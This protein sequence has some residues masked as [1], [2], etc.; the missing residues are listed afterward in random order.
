MRGKNKKKM[1]AYLLVLSLSLPLG[2]MN[3]GVKR[4]EAA[5]GDWNYEII[6]S[7]TAKITGYTGNETKI[8]IPETITDT[9]DTSYHVTALGDYAFLGQSELEEITI[10]EGVTAIGIYAF[11]G[12][13]S[14]TNISLPD[15]ITDIP[16]FAFRGCMKLTN[17][18]FPAKLKSIGNFAFDSCTSLTGVEL[19]EG[20]TT[21]G[22]NVFYHCTSFRNIKLPSTL[23]SIGKKVF[24]DTS[25]QS[26]TIP[27]NVSSIGDGLFNGLDD[28]GENSYIKINEIVVDEENETY[29]S[30][31]NCNAI[32]ETATDTLLYGSNST[33]KIP[34]GVKII[35]RYAFSGCKDLESIEIPSTV[36][37]VEGHIF[38]K[39]SNLS[40][41]TVSSENRTFDSRGDCNGIIETASNMLVSGC[42]ATKIPADV[43]EIQISAFSGCDGLTE[44]QLPSG[45]QEIKDMTFLGCSGLTSVRIPSG[46]RSIGISAFSRCSSLKSVY[47]PAS[48]EK[49]GEF[50]G[51]SSNGF[52]GCSDLVIY[53]ATGAKAVEFA[54]EYDIPYSFEKMPGEDDTPGFTPPPDTTPPPQVTQPPQVTAT[55]PAS[56]TTP[57]PQVTATPAPSQTT[58][59]PQV[60]ATPAPS[61]T[62]PPSPEVIK[63][64]E[65]KPGKAVIKSLKN[66]S[67]KK[68][69]VTLSRKISGAAGYQ[70]AYATKSSMKQQKK[71]GFKGTSITIS[72][73]K[74]KKTYYFRVRAYMKTGGNTVYGTWSKIKSVKVKK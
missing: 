20:V 65:T 8:Q 11:C 57:V 41:I 56:Q 4:V 28:F 29:D 18:Q 43:N 3:M 1:L 10:P 37:D 48:V 17:I 34:E 73:L 39:C 49:F 27:K 46:V 32:I 54:E 64:Q 61:P 63:P 51:E 24:V 22:A 50:A 38:A 6:G 70:V 53:T 71:K 16:N 30:R 9:N 14:L 31:D 2:F 7:D 42:K 55:P 25:L 62:I 68:V 44:I 74:K 5:D 47:I 40:K 13:S 23:E 15:E 45:M 35:G 67:G 19:P 52:P 21:L 59:V 33:S 26:L 72:G 36:N 60:T 58:P 12:C 66:K 69:T